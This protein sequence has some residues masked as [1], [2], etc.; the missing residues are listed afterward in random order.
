MEASSSKIQRNR[1]RKDPRVEQSNSDGSTKKKEKKE[2]LLLQSYKK[3]DKKIY[4][5]GNEE[6]YYGKRV[7][8]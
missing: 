3:C 2:T 7:R 1:K 8:K 4:P 6:G 5:Y